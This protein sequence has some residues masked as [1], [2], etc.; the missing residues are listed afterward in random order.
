MTDI[1][2]VQT[3]PSFDVLAGADCVL[4]TTFRRDGTAVA[5]PLAHV[6]EDGVVYVS[7]MADSGKV[8]R[9]RRD[10]TVTI[11]NCT[12]RGKPTG[13][14]Y[15]GVATVLSGEEGERA[16]RRTEVKHWVNRPIHFYQ[17]RLRR[18][19]VVGLAIRPAPLS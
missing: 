3:V 6:V 8:K 5:T 12:L 13:P 9:L 7:T 1:Q 4:L 14:T 17:R 19:V 16:I 10:A 18:R 11:A 2:S 15:H